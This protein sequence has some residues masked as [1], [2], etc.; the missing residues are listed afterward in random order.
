MLRGPARETRDASGLAVPLS[1]IM[2][3][4]L[5]GGVVGFSLGLTGGGGSLLA[6]PLIVYVVGVTDPHRAIG[7]SAVAVSV[8]AA[9]NALTYARIGSVRWSC[10]GVFATA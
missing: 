3:G 9:F 10:A 8:S 2:L 1:Q 4:L 6:V 7:T 5:S